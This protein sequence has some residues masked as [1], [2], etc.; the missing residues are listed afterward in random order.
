MCTYEEKHR[1]VEPSSGIS[2]PSKQILKRGI[3]GFREEKKRHAEQNQESR[4]DNT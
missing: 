3:G 2:I 4:K 1:A